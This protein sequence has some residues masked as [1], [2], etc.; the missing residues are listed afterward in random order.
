MTQT[1]ALDTP[2][3]FVSPGCHIVSA[4]VTNLVHQASIDTNLVTQGYDL[5]RVGTH[6]L[7]APGA[8]A[9]KLQGVDDLLIMK[10]GWWTGLTFFNLYPFADRCSQRRSGPPNDNS[11]PFCEC[12]NW[13]APGF[14]QP[15]QSGG[16]LPSS[17][18]AGCRLGPH[19]CMG[20]GFPCCAEAA[21]CRMLDELCTA[22]TGPTLCLLA[23]SVR[24][25]PH[26]TAH[27]CGGRQGAAQRRNRDPA[28]MWGIARKWVCHR[29]NS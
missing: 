27:P 5:K 16:L 11:C 2:L 6:S 13:I 10:I 19:S 25:V 18:S 9:L 4:N 28:T 1:Q 22:A 15:L 20:P 17:H 8:M 7:R 26:P 24:I 12:C 29:L 21:K 14:S 3:S 23:R